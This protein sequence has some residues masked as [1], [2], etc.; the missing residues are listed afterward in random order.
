[1][2]LLPLV[3]CLRSRT[4][5]A[6]YNGVLAVPPALSITVSLPGEHPEKASA[7]EINGANLGCLRQFC[8][9][10][11]RDPYKRRPGRRYLVQVQRARFR[12][13]FDSNRPGMLFA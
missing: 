3:A 7:R 8:S 13:W 12:S 6:G 4:R 11:S 1:M 5:Y 10:T 9:F 2:P